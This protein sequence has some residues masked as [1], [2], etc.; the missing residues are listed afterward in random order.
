MRRKGWQKDKGVQMLNINNNAANIKREILVRIARLTLDGA[1]K[2]EAHYIPSEIEP[3]GSKPFRCCIYRDREILRMRVIASLGSSIEDYDEHDDKPLSDY[4]DEALKREKPTLPILTVLHEACNAC[5]RSHYMVTNACQGCFARPCMVNCPKKAITVERSA[6]I[7]SNKCINCG[8]CAQNCP[9]HSIIRVPVPCEDA[10]PVGA[11][12]KDETGREKIDFDKC[13]F[14]GQCMRSCPFGAMMDKSQL[15]DVIVR[16]KNRDEG[17]KDKRRVVAMYAP[18]IAAQFKAEAGQLEAALLAAGFD[19]VY[20][21][22]LGA[23]VCADKE[24]A[25]FEERMKRGD[26]MMT[27]SCCPA[28]VRAVRVHSPSLNEC[29]SET[30]TPMHYTAEIAKKDDESCITVFVGPCLAKKMEGLY[31]GLVDYV[32]TIEEVGALFIAKGIDIASMQKAPAAGD[33]P[34]KTGR[35]FA[36]SGG[37][38]EAVRVRLNKDTA[39]R[40]F[41][42][43][44]LNKAGMKTLAMYGMMNEGKMPTK[45]DTPN[46]IEVMACEGGCI[47]G[48]S[49][50]T[51]PKVADVLLKSYVDGGK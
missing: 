26:K 47:S 51:N 11:I 3:K 31:D 44:G 22:A 38:A 10:C 19:S 46:L 15:V 4:A 45:E 8:L 13:I 24:A 20:E 29:V 37:V 41:A 28:Y 48:P 43:N 42:I 32:L 1:L 30:K 21:V 6:V 12:T 49:V 2:D 9:Y 16:M 25:E 23:D 40:P 33:I 36:K 34:T 14:C 50:V 18:A 39:C 27:S 5:V 17:G 7:D 35:A